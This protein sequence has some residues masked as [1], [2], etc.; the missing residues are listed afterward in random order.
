MV[1]ERKFPMNSVPNY[2]CQGA[3]AWDETKWVTGELY[4]DLAG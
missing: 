2:I 4:T 1:L 3:S